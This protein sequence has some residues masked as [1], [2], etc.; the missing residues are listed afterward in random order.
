MLEVNTA[1]LTVYEKAGIMEFG[2]FLHERGTRILATRGTGNAIGVEYAPVGGPR[3]KGGMIIYEISEEEFCIPYTAATCEN[4]INLVAINLPPLREAS[5]TPLND[6]EK[7]FGVRV[8][9]T[10]DLNEK[11]SDRGGYILLDTI[12]HNPDRNDGNRYRMRDDIIVVTDPKYYAQIMTE[13]SSHNLI[14][15]DMIR[16]INSNAI[17]H[18]EMTRELYE[19]R[20]II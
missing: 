20:K 6:V 13:L 8:E 7:E 14:P 11:F 2:R 12:F 9:G 15:T 1:L 16:E 5:K 3:Y 17:Q 18:T 19:D 10:R 4:R